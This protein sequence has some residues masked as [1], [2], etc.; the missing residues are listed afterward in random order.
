MI[1]WK[2]TA[3]NKAEMDCIFYSTLELLLKISR[4][5][6]RQHDAIVALTFSNT[7]IAGSTLH[8]LWLFAGSQLRVTPTVMIVIGALNVAYLIR[9]YIFEDR[10][11]NGLERFR[12]SQ[13]NIICRYSYLYYLIAIIYLSTVVYFTRQQLTARYGIQY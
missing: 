8:L 4:E 5:G 2:F 10:Y 3:K 1:I 12:S 13:H 7:V 9:R 11:L 6:K